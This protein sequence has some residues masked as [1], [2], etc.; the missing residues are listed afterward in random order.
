MLYYCLKYR[1]YT[2]FSNYSLTYFFL[3]RYPIQN[4][5]LHLVVRSLLSP[6]ISDSSCLSLSIMTLTFLKR[7]GSL[8][9]LSHDLGLCNISTWYIDF[10]YYWKRYQRSDVFSVLHVK[11]HRIDMGH[12]L[13]WPWSL[14]SWSVCQLSPLQRFYFSFS[15]YTAGEANTER[16]YKYPVSV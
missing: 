12:C 4:P 11:V 2:T 7:N 6:P 16:L 8:H 14:G 3:P 15:N 5:A 13:C 9:S 1:T 10:M